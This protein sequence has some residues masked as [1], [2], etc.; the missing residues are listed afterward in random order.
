[1]MKTGPIE[2]CGM[3]GDNGTLV[4]PDVIEF[5]HCSGLPEA[6]AVGQ[7]LVPKAQVVCTGVKDLIKA[8]HP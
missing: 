6:Q 4:V 5:C 8:R 2:P 1:M 3:V 7:R